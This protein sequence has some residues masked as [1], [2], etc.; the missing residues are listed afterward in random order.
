MQAHDSVA[1]QEMPEENMAQYQGETVKL[2]RLEKTLDT[3]LVS[4][5]S[6]PCLLFAYVFLHF[7]TA[8]QP[9]ILLYSL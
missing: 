5:L 7:P 9:F 4:L 6:Y 2:V 3:P 1:V 8:S